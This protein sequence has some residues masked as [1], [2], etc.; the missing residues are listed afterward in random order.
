[1]NVRHVAGRA[2]LGLGLLA[3]AAALPA[4]AQCPFGSIQARVQPN[5]STPWTVSLNLQVGQSFRVGGFYNGTGLLDTTGNVRLEVYTPNGV[6]YPANGSY[7]GAITAGTHTVRA[8]C[9]SLN[10]YAYVYVSVA[11]S[12]NARRFHRGMGVAWGGT[13]TTTANKM[14]WDRASL[15]QVANAGA[16]ATH[17]S[18]DWTSD[19]QP[20]PTSPISWTYMDHMV[21][22]AQLRGLEMFAFTGQVPLWARKYTQLP[23]H[24]TPPADA[25]EAQFRSFHTQLAQ[26]YCGRVKY[27]EFWNE[28][29]GCGWI[30]DNCSNTSDAQIQEYVTWLM[31]WYSAMKAGCPDTVLA[32]GG[33]ACAWGDNVD[34]PRTDCGTYVSKIYEKGGGNSFDAVAMHPYGWAA[35]PV[36]PASDA[37]LQ[38]ALTSTAS[39]QPR[40]L[41]TAAI[42]AVTQVLAAN[43]HSGRKLWL[44]EWGY[45]TENDS[46]QAQLVDAAFV[47]LSKPKYSNVFE[48]R[49][50]TLT[51]PHSFRLATPTTTAPPF[52]FT[53]RPGWYTFRTWSLGANTGRVPLVNPGMEFQGNPVNSQHSS[54]WYWGLN[55]AWAFHSQYPRTGNEVLGRKFG[56]YSAGTTETVNQILNVNFLPSRTY[57]LKA[58]VNGGGDGTGRVP[59]EL[60]YKKTDGN[61]QLLRRM[62]FPVGS[63]WID[64][65][66]THAT[67][68]ASAEVGRPIW[69][70]FAAGGLTDI[71]FDDLQLSVTPP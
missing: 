65:S 22:E 6:V 3:A 38:L 60:G 30:G 46:L 28:Q 50:L 23:A 29:N 32:V 48:A 55:G 63:Q 64:V 53:L 34:S 10:D 41:N 20:T 17:V 56:Y 1:V 13:Q 5:V 71:W 7:V 11:G 69:V 35:D 12:T 57:R 37:V 21:Q 45:S 4:A 16:T 67:G 24:R 39:G 14:A 43:N 18:F 47:E 58:S 54:L 33:L 68:A 9:G 70:R 31:R 26:R 27:Y 8:Y 2:A 52:G 42:A 49:Y 15:D 62:E 25:Y 36:P 44:D 59:I 51:T 40:I 66:F 19:V 61:Y